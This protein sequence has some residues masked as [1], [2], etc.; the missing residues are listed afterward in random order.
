MVAVSVAALVTVLPAF[1]VNIPYT[2][3]LT[4]WI[5][6]TPEAT[7]LYTTDASPV[8]SY[9]YF[10]SAFPLLSPAIQSSFISQG[11]TCE[12]DSQGNLI[13][14]SQWTQLYSSS[15]AV[16]TIVAWG[17]SVSVGIPQATVTTSLLPPVT[18]SH[19]EVI[20]STSTVKETLFQVATVPPIIIPIVLFAAYLIL[21]RKT[22]ASRLENLRP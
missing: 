1:P 19:V 16:Q 5:T 18:L 12:V 15:P 7:A 17:K 13:V 8:I 9:E 4:H 3:S 20:S 2:F 22:H 6:S 21:Q 10:C 14:P 11:L